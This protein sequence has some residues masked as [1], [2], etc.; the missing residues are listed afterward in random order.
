[1]KNIQNLFDRS[2]KEIY[3]NRRK[4]Y[5]KLLQKGFSIED[6]IKG[7]VFGVNYDLMKKYQEGMKP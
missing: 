2:M 6:A 3:K 1:M 7:A 5:N 4:A